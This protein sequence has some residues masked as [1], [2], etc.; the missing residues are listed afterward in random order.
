M[1]ALPL[2]LASIVPKSTI[3][4]ALVSER[5]HFGHRTSAS[6]SVCAS[7]IEGWLELVVGGVNVPCSCPGDLSKKIHQSLPLFRFEH[8]T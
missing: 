5:L 6:M 4:R 1:Y 2:L 7:V 8:A 3:A